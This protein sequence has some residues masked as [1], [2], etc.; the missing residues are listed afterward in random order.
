MLLVVRAA[1]KSDIFSPLTILRKCC[2]FQL[3]VGVDITRSGT[4]ETRGSPHKEVFLHFIAFRRSAEPMANMDEKAPTP[5]TIELKARTDSSSLTTTDASERSLEAIA[6]ERRLVWKLD[7]Y[8]LPFL[9]VIFF[10]A[11]MGRSDI[12][13][14]KIAGMDT[15]LEITAGRYANII[16]TFI[17][18]YIL[19]QPAGTM[20]LRYFTPPLQLG[21]AMIAWGAVTVW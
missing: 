4:K 3:T 19:F 16:T 1:D 11:Q 7:L 2:I 8:I 10:L 13:N 18:G 5:M 6:F 12:A 21:G 20:L 9:A 15:D 14:A 17:A